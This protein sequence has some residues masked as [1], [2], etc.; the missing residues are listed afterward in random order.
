MRDETF[1]RLGGS[2]ANLRWEGRNGAR[3]FWAKPVERME[4]ARPLGPRNRTQACDHGDGDTVKLST[5][6]SAVLSILN[7]I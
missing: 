5:A 6:S 4:A 7:C 2:D 1:H 3:T